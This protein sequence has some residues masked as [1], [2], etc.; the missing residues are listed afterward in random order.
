MSSRLS[1]MG[2]VALL[3][4]GVPAVAAPDAD[5]VR[6]VPLVRNPHVFVSMELAEG[7]TD[8]VR[9]A[10]HSG[11]RTTFTYTVDLRLAVPVWLDRTVATAV[12]A[13][14]VQ[15][16][17]LTRRYTVMRTIDG[18]VA[19]V[20]V[21]EDEAVVRDLLTTF[22]RLPLFSTAA[23]EPNREYY[24]RVRASLSP[25]RTGFVWPWAGGPSGQVKFTFIP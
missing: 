15:Y 24:V 13:T 8:D 7:F 17:N 21:T 19:E 2:L 12:V 23:L 25:R 6:V 14:S 20:R 16:D 4:S 10:V 1:V 5:A 9:A 18:R 3:A 22:A 11:L